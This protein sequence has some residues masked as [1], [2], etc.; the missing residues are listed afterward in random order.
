MEDIKD[1]A[2][3]SPGDIPTRKKLLKQM[4]TDATRYKSPDELLQAKVILSMCFEVKANEFASTAKA[5]LKLL[6]LYPTLYHEPARKETQREAALKVTN[7]LCSTIRESTFAAVLSRA[8]ALQLNVV[9]TRTAPEPEETIDLSDIEDVPLSTNTQF[10]THRS[11]LL[12][13]K[14]KMRDHL[15]IEDRIATL[16]QERTTVREWDEKAASN[17]DV[18]AKVVLAYANKDIS[19][20]SSEKTQQYL[21]KAITH[22][23]KTLQKQLQNEPTKGAARTPKTHVT[24]TIEESAQP[25]EIEVPKYHSSGAL[26]P[27]PPESGLG[28]D[29]SYVS[30]VVNTSE[31]QLVRPRVPHPVSN[32]H[33]M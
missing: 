13:E 19:A 11:V 33:A 28:K 27:P 8:A 2:T 25:S 16:V 24:A 20:A 22:R 9:S 17:K 30:K 31:V 29:H 32:T 21:L 7:L 23:I 1:L 4:I 3:F 6:R 5:M 10:T 18:A 15:P 12:E 26:M 14:D